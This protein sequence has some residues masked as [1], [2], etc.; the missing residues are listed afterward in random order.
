MSAAIAGQILELL[1]PT[2]HDRVR[3][4]L[5]LKVQ[6]LNGIDF[7]EFEVIPG[8]PRRYVLHVHFL[9]D[10]PLN[11]YGLTAQL[12]Q[13]QVL[14][15]TRITNIAVTRATRTSA[16]VLDIE[17]DRQGDYSPYLL[18]IGWSRGESM[19]RP[20]DDG[21]WRW[22]PGSWTFDFAAL[23]RPFSVAPINFR[24]GCAVGFDCAPGDD[25][26]PE[27]LPEPALD[28][29]ARDYASFRQLLIDLVAQ[30]QPAWTER[31]AADIGMALLELFAYEGDHLSYYQDAVG[32]EAYLDTA[33]QRISAKRHARLVDYQMHDGRNAWTFVHFN[34]SSGGL[35]P[36]GQQLLTRVTAPF[37]HDS[38]PPGIVV[39]ELTEDDYRGDPALAQVRVF[40]TAGEVVCRP[41][42]N[43]IHIHTWGNEQCCLPR[44]TRTAHLYTVNGGVA[45]RPPLK[46]GDYLLLEEVLGPI[47]GSPADRDP[48]HRQVVRITSVNPDPFSAAGPGA[49]A[50]RDRLFLAATDASGS[51][52]PVTGGTPPLVSSTLPLLEVTWRADD[53]LRFPLCVSAKKDDLT[54]IRGIAVARGNLVATDHGRTVEESLDFDPP[55]EDPG[56]RLHLSQGPLTMQGAPGADARAASPAITLDVWHG[57]QRSTWLPSPTLLSRGEFDQRFVV[58]IDNA[59]RAVLRF[60]DGQYGQRFV[61]VTRAAAS[62]RVGNGAAGNIGADALWHIVRP[63]AA[64]GWPDIV[65]VRNPLPAE[66]GVD[67][68]TI[69]E[70]RQYAP[71]AFRASQH[72]A[73][74]EEDYRTAA[75]T[76]DG[77]SGAMAAFRWTGS[78]YTVFV[79]I[80][81]VDPSNVVTNERG[82]TSL[83]PTF[84]QHVLDA[85]TSYRLAGYDLEIRAARY[86]PLKITIQLCPKAGYFGGDVA[87]AVSLALAGSTRRA[88]GFFNALN[89]T[90]GQPV[91]LSALYAAIE[92]VDGVESA[93]VTVFH[94]Y[95]RQ[96]GNELSTGLIPVGAWEIA[97]LDNDPSNMENGTLTIF[98]GDAA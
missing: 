85:L 47:T 28:Y 97:R 23:D 3:R 16:K 22:E 44:G 32:T 65:E 95:G 57:Q 7:I 12:S 36:Q 56:I 25:C 19:A 72:R 92:A 87:R 18:A 82:L 75:L 74:T 67:P 50:M 63:R 83:A 54:H 64:Q 91:Y 55:A 21:V 76:V 2:C 1:G 60:G 43:T 27:V 77:V 66:D 6:Q 80:D 69:E 29:L 4:D 88:R 61:G 45:Q 51:P 39:R 98:S 58:D 20:G 73:V 37:R 8:P 52:T 35:V 62:Y 31:S 14:G 13:L 78:W 42:N 59:G 79:A 68:E 5:L 15:G 81:P 26:P 40:E 84:K 89:F 41:L 70:V 38:Q 17:V 71:A 49:D 11:A 33:R 53:A 96:P 9:L 46:A 94:P 48:S 93:T 24:P 86:L 34:V 90:F 30:R 10:L